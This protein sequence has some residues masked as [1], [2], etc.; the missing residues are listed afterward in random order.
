MKNIELLKSLCKVYATS[1]DEGN[2]KDFI[3]DYVKENQANWK[4][5]PTIHDNEELQDCL[6]LEF[7]KPRTAIF[8]HMDSIGFSV[9]YGNE[10]IKIGGPR[11]AT[12]FELF[13]RDSRGDVECTLKV[14]EE[15]LFYESD[16]EIDRGTPLA[17]KSDF[18]ESEEYVQSC[19]MD[20]RLGVWSALQV[21]EDMEDGLLVFSCWEEHGGGSVAYLSRYLYEQ[22]NLKQALIAD[23]T[24]VTEGV[25][26]GEGVAVSIRD[27]GIPRRKYINR[28]I[29]LVQESEVPFQLEVESSGGS[30]GNVIQ[31]SPYPINWCFIGAPEQHVH[32]PDEKVH[33]KDIQAMV[34]LYRY[35]MKKL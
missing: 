26:A 1:G 33:K 16:R 10:L 7:G 29:E 14:E 17:F 13:G 6:V 23:I 21:A 27:S 15:K 11:T 35:L 3:L 32:S 30:D 18:R 8:A 4:V 5:Q 9:R 22:F 28:I 34:D 25:K 2:M 31:R 20:N 24:W 19:Y 12:G